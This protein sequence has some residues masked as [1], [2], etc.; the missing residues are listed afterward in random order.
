MLNRFMK[1]P[2]KTGTPTL[3][4]E[5]AAAPDANREGEDV[6]LIGALLVDVK[7]RVHRKLID[8]LNLARLERMPRE[9]LRRSSSPDTLNQT[10]FLSMRKSLRPSPRKSSTNLPDL[11]PLSLC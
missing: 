6:N 1:G 4:E 11:V 9:D 7:V 10:V 8:D 3:S 2:A 5:V